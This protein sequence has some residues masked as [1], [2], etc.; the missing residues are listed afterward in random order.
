MNTKF[1][2]FHVSQSRLM[3]KNSSRKMVQNPYCKSPPVDII[4]NYA[5][6]DVLGTVAM[7]ITVLLEA[8]PC[9]LLEIYLPPPPKKISAH[10][11]YN[12]TGSKQALPKSRQ[13]S[14]NL[15]G[16]SFHKTGIF[17]FELISSTSFP[18][19]L[20]LSLSDSHFYV[21]FSFPIWLQHVTWLNFVIYSSPVPS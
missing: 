20:S 1:L 16:V 2:N 18:P 19:T 5:K 7:D 10:V 8:T 13:L 4:L 15:H 12:E 3:T 21:N 6:S 17:N 9:I 14:T 11:L